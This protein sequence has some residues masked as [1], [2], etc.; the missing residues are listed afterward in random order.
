MVV[1]I[2]EVIQFIEHEAMKRSF[3]TVCYVIPDIFFGYLQLR[4][5]YK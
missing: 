5:K 2:E 4:Q 1:S 3:S